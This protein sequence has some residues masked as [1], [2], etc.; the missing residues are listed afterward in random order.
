MPGS[1]AIAVGT[2]MPNGPMRNAPASP[3]TASAACTASIASTDD[4][5]GDPRACEAGDLDRELDR[6]AFAALGAVSDERA[7]AHVMD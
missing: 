4:D 7:L 6:S 2:F 1:Y 5:H 3:S